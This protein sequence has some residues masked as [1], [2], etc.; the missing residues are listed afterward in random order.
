[1]GVTCSLE[2]SS[3]IEMDASLINKAK[4]AAAFRA[5][6]ENVKSGMV[7]GIGS[8]STVVFAVEA[9]SLG[10]KSGKYRDL[11]CVPTSFQA[12]QLILQNGLRLGDVDAFPEI[13]IAIDGADEVDEALNCI[14]GGGGCHLQEKVIAFSAKTFVVIADFRKDSKILG[15]KWKKGIPVSCVPFARSSVEIT[16]K[17]MGYRPILRMALAKAGP[18]VT[19]NGGLLF[20]VHPSKAVTPERVLLVD[21]ELRSVPG[22]I[23]TGLFCGIARMAYF[24]NQDGSVTKRVKH[25]AKF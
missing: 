3:V 18:L 17:R 22:V 19:D 1:M 24:G 9:V 15:D 21:T 4:R 6:D 8:G 14:K 11:I 13:D 23:E 7:V 5:V 20:D 12:R 2:K 10:V 16:L 25:G